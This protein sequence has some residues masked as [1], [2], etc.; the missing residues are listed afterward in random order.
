MLGICNQLLACIALCT[1][2]V[3]LVN[4]RR[5]RNA[6]LT[7]APLAFVGYATEMAGYQLI[8]TQFLPK[9]IGSGNPQL[10][11]QGWLLS[12][13]CVLAMVALAATMLELVVTWRKPCPGG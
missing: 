8:T 1:I 4:R 11:F 10:A 9:M 6:G 3:Y 7:L 13:T 5:A 2:T 12:T